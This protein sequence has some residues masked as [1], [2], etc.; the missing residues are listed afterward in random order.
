MRSSQKQA[1]RT[2]AVEGCEGFV[3]GYGRF[4]EGLWRV[5]NG[6]STRLSCASWHFL[7]RVALQ[8]KKN[9]WFFL[10]SCILFS[11]T[12]MR[13]M[14]CNDRVTGL[15]H[16]VG[17]KGARHLP[18]RTVVALG[19]GGIIG[20]AARRKAIALRDSTW[21]KLSTHP[22]ICLLLQQDGS[23]YCGNLDLAAYLPII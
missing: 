17:V 11:L 15:K 12:C 6:A 8:K 23:V 22:Q 9:P 20:E 16:F 19:K 13:Y 2:Q 4:V 3:E 21:L 7:W 14:M 18:Y 5:E 1:G 10:V